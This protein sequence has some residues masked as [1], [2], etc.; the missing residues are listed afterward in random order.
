MK[1]FLPALLSVLLFTQCRDEG[2]ALNPDGSM[3]AT[4]DGSSWQADVLEAAYVDGTLTLSGSSLDERAIVM[5][6]AIGGL[7]PQTVAFLPGSPD[8]LTYTSVGGARTYVSNT[9]GGDGFL[10]ITEAD[11]AQEWVSGRFEARCYRL[12]ESGG[13]EITEGVF[14]KVPY[15]DSLPPI[16]S[17]GLRAVI[18]GATWTSDSITTTLSDGQIQVQ[19]LGENGRQIHFRIPENAD[20]GT[21]DLDLGGSFSATYI[22]IQGDTLSAESGTLG[23]DLLDEDRRRLEG[24]FNFEATN[25]Q[26]AVTLAD[27]GFEINY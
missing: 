12:Q 18:D 8:G 10:R 20:P 21:Y 13:V 22:T 11:T 16:F 9:A 27:G 17:S 7:Q 6:V 25:G 4:I 15:T 3:K 14:T 26:Q 5:G 2:P 23:I 19:S 24:A 1:Y